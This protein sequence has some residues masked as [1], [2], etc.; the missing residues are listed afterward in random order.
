M[1]VIAL[2]GNKGGAG[3]T[4]LTV[5]LA[6]TLLAM[7]RTAILDADPQGSA[8]QWQSIGSAESELKVIDAAQGIADIFA[9]AAGRYEHLVI[10]CPPSVHAA[11]THAALEVSDIALIP[12]QPSPLDLWATVHIEQAV[13]QARRTNPDLRALLVINQLES[14]TRLSRLIRDALAELELPAADTAIH[15]RAVYR[16]SVL[17]GRSVLDM[18][19][20]GAAAVAEIRNLI[21]EVVRQ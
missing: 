17:E 18:G 20:S 2:V 3:K 14:R 5:N 6:A 1:A 7:G 9:G 10:D 13:A 16:A 21:N 12:V 8:L 19:R 15:R 4:T 11:Q